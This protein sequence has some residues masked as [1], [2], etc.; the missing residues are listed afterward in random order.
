MRLLRWIP[1]ALAAPLLLAGQ[2][3][4]EFSYSTAI[5]P[6][7]ASFGTGSTVLFL[8]VSQ[9][10]LNGTQGITI[11]RLGLLSTTVAPPGPTDT[12]TP[13]G[14]AVQDT[15]TI[16]QNSPTIGTGTLVI[17]GFLSFQRADKDGQLSSFTFNPLAASNKLSVTIG[18]TTYSIDPGIGSL[19]YS[20]GTTG[21]GGSGGL[22]INLSVSTVPEPASMALLGVGGLLLAAPRLRRLVRRMARP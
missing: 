5:V 10:N 7:A 8:P 18:G 17:N 11:A 20:Q 1:A 6:P 12:T 22:S 2:A 19:A 4:A 21:V 15:I 3:L 9:S 13:P 14:I 16:T